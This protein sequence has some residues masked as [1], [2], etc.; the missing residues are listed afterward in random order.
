MRIPL[1]RTLRSRAKYVFAA[2]ISLAICFFNSSAPENFF[3]S[4]NFFQ[5]LTSMRSGEKLPE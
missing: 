3:S 2:A 5:N 4:R 1:A